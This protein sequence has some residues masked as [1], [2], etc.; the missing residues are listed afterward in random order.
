MFIPEET[1]R[2]LRD[3]L[4]DESDTDFMNSHST[5]MDDYDEVQQCL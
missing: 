4:A 3:I 1:V 2:W 5:K